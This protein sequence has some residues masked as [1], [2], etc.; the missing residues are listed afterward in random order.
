MLTSK[1]YCTSSNC[2]ACPTIKKITA[3]HQKPHEISRLL[4][5]KP[6]KQHID[7]SS[8][9]IETKYKKLYGYSKRIFS[10]NKATSTLRTVL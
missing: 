3:D 7:H 1:N 9:V 5:P 6:Q 10:S 8:S 4:T 2:G